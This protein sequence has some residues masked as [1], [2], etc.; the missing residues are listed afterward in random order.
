[1]PEDATAWIKVT[2]SD[3]D[4]APSSPVSEGER[5]FCPGCNAMF[6]V[7]MRK[8]CLRKEDVRASKVSEA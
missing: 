2:Y 3:T 1:M 4:R 5:L 8:F 7:W 6:R